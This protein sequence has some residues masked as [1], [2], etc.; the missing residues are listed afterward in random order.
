MEQSPLKY[1]PKK[2]QIIIDFL[3][4]I[5][6]SLPNLIENVILYGSRARLDFSEYSDYDI[7]I[8]LKKKDREIKE[9]IYEAGYIVFDLYSKLI[10]C[11][12]WDV[13]EWKRK[14]KFSIGRNIHKEGIVLYE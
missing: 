13:S 3:K 6:M 14:Q 9:K 7:L 1:D 4:Q 2:D 8:V 5:Q 12:I 10:S 11:M